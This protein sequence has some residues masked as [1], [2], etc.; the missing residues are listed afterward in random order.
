VRYTLPAQSFFVG[1]AELPESLT[2]QL[3][4]FAKALSGRG[5]ASGK[6][7]IE[8]HTDASGSF[9][10][11]LLLS[12]RRADAVKAYL[13]KHGVDAA[14]LKAVGMGSSEP[15][16]SIDPFA[17]ENRRVEIIRL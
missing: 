13:V 15:K 7:R 3:D 2:S 14:A 8:V 12:Q 9:E 10:A 6:V 5:A 17:A 16:L 1:S 4:V 11:N